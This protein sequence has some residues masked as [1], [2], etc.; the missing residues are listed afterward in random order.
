MRPSRCIG[1]K[2][3]GADMESRT[4]AGSTGEALVYDLWPA[5]GAWT[6]LVHGLSSNAKTWWATAREL[7]NRGVSAVTVDQ[8]SHG[9]SDR[10]GGGYDWDTL[11]SDL[12]IVMDHAEIERA[13][14]VGQ[15][16]G[17]SVVLEFANR[18]PDR[19]SGM[20]GIDGGYGALQHRFDSWDRARVALRPPDIP[21]VDRDTMASYVR[22]GYPHWSE[23][24]IQATVDNFRD[25]AGK[26]ERS[27]PIPDHMQIVRHLWDHDPAPSYQ[28]LRCPSAIVVA[29]ETADHV[30]VSANEVIALPGSHDL[31]VERPVDVA[32]IIADRR[33]RW[34]D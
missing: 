24:G 5:D 19:A 31:H 11:V 14:V 23:E 4:V 12:L 10:T 27:L 18:Q 20:I 16:W 29:S 13:V 22:R 17:A 30:A 15:S 8:R 9:R 32:E 2:R 28:A 7:N 6:L 1:A 26:L 25:N 3:Y 33:G 21:P 34:A